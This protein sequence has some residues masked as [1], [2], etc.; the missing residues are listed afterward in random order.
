MSVLGQIENI[1]GSFVSEKGMVKSD[2]ELFDVI[3]PSNEE[4]I[5]KYADCTEQEVLDV[6]ATANKV[7]KE[8]NKTDPQSL[9]SILINKPPV[10]TRIIH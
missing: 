5:G 9:A 2:G 4:I 6:I 3:N 10:S 1:S 8:W 7:Q